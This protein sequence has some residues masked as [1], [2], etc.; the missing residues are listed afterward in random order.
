MI[1]T[2]RVASDLLQKRRR[3]AFFFLLP[4]LAEGVEI[5]AARFII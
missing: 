4:A 2:Q 1:T 3:V 5:G